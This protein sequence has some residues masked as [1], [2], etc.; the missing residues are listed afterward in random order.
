MS[1]KGDCFFEKEEESMSIKIALA[2]NPNCGKTTLFNA[3]TGSNQ[4][5]G[6]WPGVTVEKKEGK[7]KGHK[8]VTIM[9][10]PGI[11]SLSPYTLEEV[12]ARN[13]LINEKPD[14]IINIV[15]GT[16]IERNLYLSTQ[17][18]ELGIPVIMAVNM[19]DIVEKSG[20]KI[21]VDKLSKKIG[22]EVVEIS[23]LKGTGIKEAAE[24]AVKA[25]SAKQAQQI[26]HTFDKKVENALTDIENM[27]GSEVPE[28]QKR[29]FA[30]KLL[31]KDDK[32]Q[33]QLKQIYQ[34]NSSI[35]Q[36]QSYYRKC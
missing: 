12:V 22:C 29:F 36:H 7:L 30:I 13:Y 19:M 3:L 34:S 25:A 20:D 32:I 15:D 27:L 2:G 14:A 18:L 17:V 6:N 31:E 23:A 10:L 35:D 26:V 4:F 11:Y 8:D 16:N 24:A 33:D 1:P 5:V 9:D 28:E 21:Y